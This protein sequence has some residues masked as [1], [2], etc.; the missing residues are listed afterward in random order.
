[1]LGNHPAR[2]SR[3]VDK[4]DRRVWGHTVLLGV[5]NSLREASRRAM[6][7]DVTVPLSQKTQSQTHAPQESVHVCPTCSTTNATQAAHAPAQPHVTPTWF[8]GASCATMPHDTNKHRNHV[9]VRAQPQWF[10]LH[11]H[12]PDRPTRGVTV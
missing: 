4:S 10:W 5:G 8:H 2:H 12:L 7:D 1:M 11:H 9:C 6:Q 3:L